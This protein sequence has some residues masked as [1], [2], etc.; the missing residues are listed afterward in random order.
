MTDLWL[1]GEF[2]PALNTPKF[3]FG[4]PSGG[5]YDA[6]PG[7]L[8]GWGGEHPL[9]IP[10]PLD[11]FVVSISAP[12][13]PRLSAP[14][15]NFWLRLGC[16]PPE[17]EVMAVPLTATE[18]WKPTRHK[19]CTA[20]SDSKY[21]RCRLPEMFSQLKT[22]HHQNAFAAGAIRHGPRWGSLERSRRSIA[23]R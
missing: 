14:N 21:L 2:F 10:F 20:L 13:A 16:A 6:P 15:T 18:W 17:T 11:A 1:S 5:A 8:V 3:V 12:S 19:W 7:P 23:G 9:P 22:H 4:D